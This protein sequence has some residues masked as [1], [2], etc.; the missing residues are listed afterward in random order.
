MTKKDIGRYL[1]KYSLVLFKG[2]VVREWMQWGTF[3]KDGRQPYRVVLL[4]DMSDDHIQAVLDT[5]T[6]ISNFYRNEFKSELE[7]RKK[8][9]RHS[10]KENG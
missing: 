2:R 5:Q 3:G 8:F 1:K 6:H 10:I 9:I 4:K 7:F